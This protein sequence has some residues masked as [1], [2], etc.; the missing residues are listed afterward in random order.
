MSSLGRPTKG[1]CIAQGGKVRDV[2]CDCRRRDKFTCRLSDTIKMEDHGLRDNVGLIV[3][4]K[5]HTPAPTTTSSAP[6]P[7]PDPSPTL[8]VAN[9][10]LLF[11]P[12]RGDIKA[13]MPQ[14]FL[15]SPASMLLHSQGTATSRLITCP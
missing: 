3:V 1:W 5:A 10:H 14:G 7:P 15:P 8:V 11:N 9:T 2:C 6:S 13:R 12:K 4:L